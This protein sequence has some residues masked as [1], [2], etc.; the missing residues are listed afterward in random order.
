M[1]FTGIV[2]AK[3]K[4]IVLVMVPFGVLI[5][6]FQN[7]G[8]PPKAA[9][10]GDVVAAASSALTLREIQEA[11]N[12]AI[13]K[14]ALSSVN[15]SQLTIVSALGFNGS[16][17][18]VSASFNVAGNPK[19]TNSAVFN[20]GVYNCQTKVNLDLRCE[21]VRND[22]TRPITLTYAKDPQG[23]DPL[24][25]G[26]DLNTL[27]PRT[28]DLDDC[29]LGFGPGET[30]MNVSRIRPGSTNIG[31]GLRCVEGSYWLKFTTRTTVTG[32]QN[33][34]S[35]SDPQYVKVVMQNGCW[36]ESRLTTGQTLAANQVYGSRVAI[37]GNWAVVVSPTENNGG[38]IEA[39]SVD[40]YN[41]DGS[42]WMFRQKIFVPEAQS[43][44]T[45][46][47]VSLKGSNMVLGSAY[48]GGSGAIYLYKLSGSTWSQVGTA[49]SSPESQAGQNFGQTVNLNGTTL[50][51]GS[52]NY[53][54]A[55]M[56][57]KAGAVYVY[58]VGTSSLTYRQTLTLTGDASNKGF[59]ASLASNGS[60][61]AVGAPQ[62]KTKEYL[63]SGSA[64]V[65]QLSG[66]IYVLAKTVT[67]SSAVED[68][69][70]FGASV[71]ISGTKLVVGAPFTA[72][73]G[74]VNRGRVH[75]YADWNNN[76]VK[77]FDGAATN[78]NYGYA[79]ALTGNYLLVGAP[80]ISSST[81]NLDSYD[82]NT[83][84]A[85]KI[86]RGTNTTS[87]NFFGSSVAASGNNVI[88]GASKKSDPNYSSGA[89]YIFQY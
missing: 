74:S 11:C 23:K 68:G 10:T 64:H 36:K 54:L 2:S 72:I 31:T 28:I 86:I 53:T 29:N 67:T 58:S 27:A 55:S 42:K 89:A 88:V 40:V 43:N 13:G 5:L 61:L 73:N 79:V 75:Y 59:G 26:A 38:V 76:P 3:T 65:Y 35:T 78:D 41:Y 83:N 48:H 71:D 4:R 62:A 80:F 60:Y 57:P 20:D 52:P 39:G 81:G 82:L 8:N 21:V 44:D 84:Y 19:I 37:D 14:P 24:V 6:L 56:Y 12:N 34:G 70:A 87:N 30:T 66:A 1:L 22:A 45:I 7:C 50:F 49:I 17:D 33:S 16:G 63:G 32:L 69:S 46:S 47:S 9:G 77:T 15:V 18:K 85:K 51:V 25:A